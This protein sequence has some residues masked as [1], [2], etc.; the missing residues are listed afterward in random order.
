MYLSEKEFEKELCELKE[1]CKLFKQE[2][3]R[4]LEPIRK[5]MKYLTEI[6][7][8]IKKR[9]DRIFNPIKNRIKELEKIGEAENGK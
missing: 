8:V 6:I 4:L 2:Y 7:R 5:R 3:K 1:K 9:E